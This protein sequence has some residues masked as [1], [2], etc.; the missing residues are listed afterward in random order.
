[1]E[2]YTDG[3]LY[4]SSEFKNLLTRGNKYEDYVL[5]IMNKSSYIFPNTYEK[6]EQQSNGEPDFIDKITKEKFDAKLAVSEEQCRAFCGEGNFEFFIDKFLEQN[7]EIYD[8]LVNNK[9]QELCVEKIMTKQLNKKSTKSKNIIFFFTFPIGT[10]FANSLTSIVCS[11]YI[12]TIFAKIRKIANGRKI[13]TICP[14]LDG[15]YEIRNVDEKDPES[16][17]NDKLDKYFKWTINQ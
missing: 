8:L 11:S 10:L 16:I 1:M 5:E 14:T 15:Y 12:D 3:Q 13:F 9:N 4:V 17:K 7:N 2:F 6:I